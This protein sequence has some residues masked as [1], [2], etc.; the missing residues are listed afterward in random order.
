[1]SHGSTITI[2]GS[3]FGTN[4]VNGDLW[5][6]MESGS[7]SPT[8]SGT[9]DSSKLAVENAGAHA[10]TPNSTKNAVVRYNTSSGLGDLAWESPSE[11]WY[12]R[13]WV[14]LDNNWDWGAPATNEIAGP[15]NYQLS[16]VK[17]LSLGASGGGFNEF[18]KMAF[19][20]GAVRGGNDFILTTENAGAVPGTTWY[21]S[22]SWF[23]KGVWHLF[24][25]EF[26]NSS[27]LL[28]ADGLIRFTVDGVVR[29]EKTN[30]ITAENFDVPRGVYIV[31]L[32]DT[33]GSWDY[34]GANTAYLDDFY[35]NKSLARVEIGNA[36]TYA[37][38]TV[39]EV[40]I[41]SAWSATSITCTVNTGSFSPGAAYLF[42]IDEDGTVSAGKPITVE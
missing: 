7:F 3:G 34:D 13:H 22:Y 32:G 28:A 38:S 29:A 9:G 24:Q 10:R 12:I 35:L 39:R 25:F 19:H 36:S 4:N 8:W 16:N 31:G 17:F 27:G 37:A 42:V 11:R 26:I 2:A 5:D 18:F 15:G 40:Q 20:A 23:T 33:S 30:L 14:K 1:V 21:E 6:N 41:P